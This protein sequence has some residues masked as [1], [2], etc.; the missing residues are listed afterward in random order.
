[1]RHEYID[2]YA[3]LDSPVHRLPPA[4]KLAVALALV[5]STVIVPISAVMYFAACAFL[6]FSVIF[7]ARLPVRFVAL[8]LLTL[9]P[10]AAGVAILA[11]MQ[12]DGLFMLIR[13]LVKSNLCLLTM[14]VLSNTTPFAG[15]LGVL[16]SLRVPPLLI[17]VLAL[18]Y[19]Y[20]F[21]L[22]DQSERMT[23]ARKSR[24]FAPRRGSRWKTA[25]GIVGQLFIRSTERAERI[26]AAMSAR[27]WR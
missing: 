2:R 19:R 22:I 8:R 15:I 10:L 21:L 26:Y 23:R 3:R 24:T 14:V 7:L 13:I 17:T 27:G 5:I 9:E 4:L 20:V 25:A 6:L 1:M 11:L 12:H 18:M 16:R